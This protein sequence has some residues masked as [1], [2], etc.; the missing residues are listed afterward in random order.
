MGDDQEMAKETLP[1]VFTEVG[2]TH[3]LREFDFEGKKV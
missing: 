2:I 1:G 3:S